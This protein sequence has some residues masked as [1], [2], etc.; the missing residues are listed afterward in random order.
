[1]KKKWME[2]SKGRK[3]IY[4]GLKSRWFIWLPQV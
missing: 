1:M 4:N 3:I 2:T